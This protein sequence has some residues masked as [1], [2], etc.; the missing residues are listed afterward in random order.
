MTCSV[1]SCDSPVFVHVRGL[2][3]L[4]YGRLMRGQPMILNRKSKSEMFLS[5]VHIAS[6]DECWPWLRGKD[7]D[8]YGL[9]SFRDGT[10][11]RATRYMWEL[12]HGR[13]PGKMQVCHRCDN[14]TCVNPRHLF[15]G[16]NLDN[17]RD[18]M[19]KGRWAGSPTTKLSGSQYAEILAL[20]PPTRA[21][22]AAQ[23]AAHYGVSADTI[24][25]IWRSHSAHIGRI[26]DDAAQLAATRFKLARLEPE[27]A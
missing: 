1:D 17:S 15:L 14:P 4:H 13:N 3:R 23:L 6:D 7:K 24:L 26:K 12:V 21:A 20:K 18:M 27:V 25:L 2:C 19:A 11:V 22:I 9:F 5:H 8:G 10:T 16:T